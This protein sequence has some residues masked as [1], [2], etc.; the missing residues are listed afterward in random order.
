MTSIIEV[1][2]L[3]DNT[4][5]ALSFVFLNTISFTVIHFTNTLKEKPDIDFPWTWWLQG[6]GSTRLQCYWEFPYIWREKGYLGPEMAKP[7]HWCPFLG[8]GY[9]S[10]GWQQRDWIFCIPRVWFILNSFLKGMWLPNHAG[11]NCLS[12][13]N[14]PNFEKLIWTLSMMMHR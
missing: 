10:S 14:I 2:K 4:F 1:K 8:C 11:M 7:W 5:A 3:I 6:M 13:R 12:S 9:R